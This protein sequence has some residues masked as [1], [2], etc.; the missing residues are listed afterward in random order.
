MNQRKVTLCD[1]NLHTFLHALFCFDSIR[2]TSISQIQRIASLASRASMLRR[3]MRP[4]TH[5]L[6]IITSAYSNPH[7]RIPLT[8]VAQPEIL[9][10]RSFAL[11]LVA[12]PALLS[13]MLNTFRPQTPQ[14]CFKYDASLF[15]ITVGVYNAESDLLLT[16][17]AVDL[18]FAVN[19]EACRRTQWN[20]VQSFSGCSSIGDMDSPTSITIY[21]MT[22]GVSKQSQFKSGT[23]RKYSVHNA[24]HAPRRKRCRHHLHPWYL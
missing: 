20:S 13:R 4:Y 11:L 5:K 19:N 24:I 6:H 10:W 8:F 21:M 2:K 22:M 14:Y 3:H 12:W 9:M 1:R 18:S 17:V 15:R 7:I 16:F 23:Q